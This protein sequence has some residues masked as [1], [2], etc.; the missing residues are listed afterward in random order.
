MTYE[1]FSRLPGDTVIHQVMHERTLSLDD[2]VVELRHQFHK[3][4]EATRYD[5][6]LRVEKGEMEVMP[7]PEEPPPRPDYLRA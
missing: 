5:I 3:P 7:D 2:W 1:E 6:W 4:V